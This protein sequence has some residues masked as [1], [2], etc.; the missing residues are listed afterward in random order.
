[1][2][3]EHSWLLIIHKHATYSAVVP[4]ACCA[5]VLRTV[6]STSRLQTSAGEVDLARYSCGDV[7]HAIHGI[8]P[9]LNEQRKLINLLRPGCLTVVSHDLHFRSAVDMHSC[10]RIPICQCAALLSCLICG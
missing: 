7:C 4:T 6:Q 8:S 3:D 1:M 2:H 10:H 5:N 9:S